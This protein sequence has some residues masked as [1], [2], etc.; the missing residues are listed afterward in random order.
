M[1]SKGWRGMEGVTGT[2]W[3]GGVHVAWKGWRGM[4]GV[5][6]TEGVAWDGGGWRAIEGVV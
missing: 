4:E 6:A 2:A 5:T 3:N 1:A